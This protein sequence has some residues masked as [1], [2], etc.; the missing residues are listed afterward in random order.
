MGIFKR[1]FK[2][3]QAEAHSQVD[4]LED[5]VKMTEQ[6]I[7]D[8]KEQLNKSIEALAQVKA[9]AI[10]TK[11]ETN[12]YKEQSTM[13]ENKAIELVKRAQSGALEPAEADRLATAALQKKE[14]S[15][16]NYK[17]SAT[18]YQKYDAQVQKLEVSIKQLKTNISK[19][20]N[21]AKMLK[22]RAKVSEATK[23]VNKQLAGIDST[24]TVSMLERMKEKIESQEAL[25]ESYGELALENRSLE[26]EIDSVLEET[27]TDGTDA[28]A[29]L[30][31]KLSGQLPENTETTDIPPTE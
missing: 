12:S 7:R 19:W 3:G 4:K 6:G 22:A 10:R 24:S 29:A 25:S 5:P 9:L 13:Y 17:L 11:N 2:I 18:N 21:E 14:Q 28:L 20:E 16:N 1:L 30:K 8:L 23:N 27:S 31:A 15:I 26:D